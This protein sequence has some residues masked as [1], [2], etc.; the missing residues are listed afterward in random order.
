[1]QDTEQTP[2]HAPAPDEAPKAETP[3]TSD[4]EIRKSKDDS[5]FHYTDWASI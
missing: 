1:M 5:G 4:D 2:R 3:K